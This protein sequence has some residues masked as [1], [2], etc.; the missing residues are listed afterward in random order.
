MLKWVSR[1]L[2]VVGWLIGGRLLAQQS[3]KSPFIGTWSAKIPD[4]GWVALEVGD[5]GSGKVTGA[6]LCGEQ[7][8]DGP[9]YTP[10]ISQR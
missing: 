3:E 2:L 8:P 10:T 6:S 5:N 9:K 1:C 7:S 4:Y